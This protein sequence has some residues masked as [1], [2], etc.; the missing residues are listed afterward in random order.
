MKRGVKG[1]LTVLVAVAAFVGVSLTAGLS[2]QDEGRRLDPP[3]GERM[4]DREPPEL[5]VADE[6]ELPVG[7]GAEQVE[8]TASLANLD[9][10]GKYPVPVG[11]QRFR[12][13][14]VLVALLHPH[15]D[16]GE[17]PVEGEFEMRCHVWQTGGRYE[18]PSARGERM[19]WLVGE[20]PLTEGNVRG[21][22][23]DYKTMLKELLEYIGWDTQTTVPSEE[24]LRK[25]GMESLISDISHV[26]VP[27]V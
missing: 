18:R 12:V 3:V 1:G 6:R 15:A 25:L 27:T 16:R 8:Y 24:S 4:A 13:V 9:D 26:Q 10:P 21:V 17:P 2:G 5:S 20:P 23:V 22:T 7:V 11:P 14:E 19:I